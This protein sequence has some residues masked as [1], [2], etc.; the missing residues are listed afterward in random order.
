MRDMLRE[1]VTPIQRQRIAINA[2][3]GFFSIWMEVFK[4]DVD[5]RQRLIDAFPGTAS[6]CFDAHCKAIARPGGKI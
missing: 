2:S 4:D 1:H 6:D 3:D 5:M